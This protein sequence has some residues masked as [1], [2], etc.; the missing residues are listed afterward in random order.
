[1]IL[2]YFFFA[3]YADSD[4][5]SSDDVDPALVLF[6]R[7]LEACNLSSQDTGF[8]AEGMQD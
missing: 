8:K 2:K 1:M 3:G 4:A 5:L 6:M 7:V